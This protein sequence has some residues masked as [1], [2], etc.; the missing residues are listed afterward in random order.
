M[1]HKPNQGEP[2]IKVVNISLAALALSL[3]AFSLHAQPVSFAEAIDLAVEKAPGIQ[4]RGLQIEAAQSEAIAAD[5]LPDPKLSVDLLDTRIAGPFEFSPRPGRNGFPRQRIGISQDVP[6]IAKRRAR[7]QQ[8][9]ADI[10]AAEAGEKDEIQNVRL[11]SALAWVDLYYAHRR[12]NI[13][14]IL[15]DSLDDLTNTVASR[16]E[17]GYSR[18]AQA[19]DPERLTAELADRR[20]RREADV[21]IAKASLSRWIRIESPEIAGK[22]PEFELDREALLTSLELLPLLQIR[23]ARVKRA[24]ADVDLARAGKNI[25]YSINASYAHRRPEYGEYVSVGVTINLPI[26]AKKRQNPRIAASMLKSEAERLRLEDL[27]R[28]LI[29]ELQSDLASNRA[30]KENWLR[31]QNTLLPLAK[32]QAEMDRISYAAGRIDLGTALNAAVVFAEAE[33]DLLDRERTFVRDT[34]RIKFTYDRNL[35]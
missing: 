31:S 30:Y 18:P 10:V 17:S 8:A 15:Q 1:A 29:A 20:A 6:S 14:K 25:D 32:K 3:P 16:L 9:S 34:V 13:L 12:L 22:A 28:Q 19:F 2:R 5:Q 24:E 11:Y 21:E 35:P 27:R 33:I 23:E 26:F 7:A 4:A